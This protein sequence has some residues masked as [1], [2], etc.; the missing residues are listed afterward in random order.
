[1]IYHDIE[2]LTNGRLKIGSNTHL[3]V[4]N[5]RPTPP[6]N[7]NGISGGSNGSNGS[8]G[9]APSRPKWQQQ[10][11]R[12]MTQNNS[13]GGNGNNLPSPSSNAEK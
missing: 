12:Q 6:P 9:G 8:N 11:R 1:L 13:G 2:E 4:S 5:Y 3:S 10:Q 7:A